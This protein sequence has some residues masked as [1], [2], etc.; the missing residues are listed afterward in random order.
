MNSQHLSASLS[1]DSSDYDELV[2][3]RCMYQNAFLWN[4]VPLCKGGCVCACVSTRV[5]DGTL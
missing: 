4:Y 5:V 3:S 2:C 1:V